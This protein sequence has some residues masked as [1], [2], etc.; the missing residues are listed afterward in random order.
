MKID[1]MLDELFGE[2]QWAAAER[3]E[4]DGYDG[5][6]ASET[7]HDPF[8]ALAVAATRTSRVQLGTAIAL[9]FARNPMSLA[10]LADDLQRY[11]RGRFVL[12]VGSQIRTHVV[13]RYSMPWSAPAERMREF[14]LAV[15]AIWASWATGERLRFRGE[16]YRHTVM[17]PMFDPGPNPYGNPPILLAGVGPRM[18]AVAGEVADGFFV[19]GFT[20]QRYLRDVTL[21]L[22]VQA[23]GGSLRGFEISGM[24]F[25]VTGPDAVAIDA[26]AT[27]VRERIAFYGSTP[28]YRRVLE[29][30]GW[31]GLADELHALSRRGRWAQMGTL[32]SDEVLDAFAVVAP[33]SRVAGELRARFG[34]LCTRIA[35]YAP[36]P[37]PDGYWA[38]IV[39]ELRDSRPTT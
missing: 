29:L 3:A 37:V 22:L 2:E 7:R 8:P 13:G 28:A 23:R 5:V 16:H 31:D 30:H 6:W 21:P 27:A 18:T 19:H 26:A 17:T 10:V 20:T 25:V 35:P 34:G 36:Y 14:L 1:L 15:R 9:A 12:G 33:P 4:R 24:P 11:S 38:P 32:I 39:A